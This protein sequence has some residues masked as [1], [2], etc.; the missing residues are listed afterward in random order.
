M[1][2]LLALAGGIGSGLTV[3]GL[4]AFGEEYGWRGYLWE[5]LTAHG[6]LGTIGGVSVLWGLW[7][8]PLILAVGFNYSD[9]RFAGV[10]AMILFTVAASWPLDELR[11]AT[12]SAVGPA[13]LH[14]AINGTAGALLLLVGGDRL[15]AAPTGLLGAVAFLPAGAMAAMMSG[16]IDN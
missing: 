6:R 2:V 1:L 5:R 4:L 14:G 3:N 13:I 16:W 12:G 9:H 15:W 8:A 7:H 11:R 10:V